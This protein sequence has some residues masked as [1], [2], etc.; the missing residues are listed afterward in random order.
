[1]KYTNKNPGYY[2]EDNGL[3]IR[4]PNMDCAVENLKVGDLIFPK[5]TDSLGILDSCII[6]TIFTG[7]EETILGTIEIQ[8]YLT[9]TRP[10]SPYMVQYINGSYFETYRYNLK[11]ILRKL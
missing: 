3:V 10:I 1:M 8:R 9:N 11:D 5:G 6:A 7:I 2:T 4:M